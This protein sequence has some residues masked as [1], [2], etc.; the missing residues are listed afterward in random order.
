MNESI[1]IARIY[2]NNNIVVLNIQQLLT[3]S[4]MK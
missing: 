4:K 3:A 2:N 1:I